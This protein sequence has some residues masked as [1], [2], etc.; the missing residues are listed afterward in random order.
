[1]IQPSFFK[2]EHSQLI[3]KFVMV[4]SLKYHILI[5][6]DVFIWLSI[7]MKQNLKGL[8]SKFIYEEIKSDKEII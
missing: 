4:L 8:F 3:A 1:M 5:S 7:K 6:F 2:Y